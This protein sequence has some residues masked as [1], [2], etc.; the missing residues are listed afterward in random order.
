M[1][2]QTM[3]RM[4]YREARQRGQR[5]QLWSAVTRR[6]RRLLA[7][8]EIHAGCPARARHYAGLQTVSIRHIRGSQNRAHDFDRDFNPLQDHNQGRWLSIAAAR[9]GGKELP[10][11][12]LIQIGDIY[13]VQD[14]HHRLSVARALGQQ[15]IEAEVTVWEVAGPSSGEAFGRSRETGGETLSGKVR[16]ASGRRQERLPLSLRDL[17]MAAGTSLKVMSWR[18]KRGSKDLAEA[19]R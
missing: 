2:D 10:P 17:V 5:G 12:K 4:L 13:F 16:V 1:L 8:S 3:P 18:W 9:R 7:L 6:P 14:G 19:L 15:A 11:V